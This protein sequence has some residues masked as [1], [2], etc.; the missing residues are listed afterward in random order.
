ML[1]RTAPLLRAPR[2]S[3]WLVTARHLAKKARGAADYVATLHGVR[4]ILPGGRVLMEHVNLKLLAGAKVGVL[5][6]NGAGKSSF[7]RVLAGWDSDIEGDYWCRGGVKVGMLEQEPQLDED[8][9]V[10]SNIMDGVSEQRDLLERFEEI[11]ER[12]AR[13]A[14]EDDMDE[15]GMLTRTVSGQLAQSSGASGVSIGPSGM[16]GMESAL[17]E[18]SSDDNTSMAARNE[19]S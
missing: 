4:K 13:A 10:L 7:L 9:D 1:W 17:V 19:W 16:V 8:R 15:L 14:P 11:N 3:P 5:G 2:G 6:A 18:A 12:L